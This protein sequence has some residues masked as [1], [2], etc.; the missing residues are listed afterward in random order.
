VG[1]R[2]VEVEV[3]FLDILAVVPLAVGQPE[4][5]LLENGILAVPQRKGKAEPLLVV[6]DPSEAVLA[7]AIG[8]RAG[9]IVGEEVPGVSVFAVVLPN[10]PPLAFTQ[11][12]SPLFPG[13]FHPVLL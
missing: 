2:A 3:V 9:M 8:P 6:G 4:E 1:W 13:I 7:P 5:A 12:G 11:I 10:R